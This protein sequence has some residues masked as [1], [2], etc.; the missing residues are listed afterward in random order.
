MYMRALGTWLLIAVAMVFNGAVR[1]LTYGRVTGPGWGHALTSLAGIAIVFGVAHLLVRRYA[2]TSTVDWLKVGLLWATL[3]AGIEFGAGHYLAGASWG[4]LLA[5]YDLLH[6]RLW[7]LVL[8]SMLL[9]P[10]FW[11]RNE[12]VP[13]IPLVRRRWFGRGEERRTTAG[14]PSGTLPTPKTMSS[15]RDARARAPIF[16]A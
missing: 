12:R 10:I 14:S 5:D 6:G 7:P 15:R 16:P 9:A 13:G 11:S 8:L 2:G 4:D 3:T 1:E